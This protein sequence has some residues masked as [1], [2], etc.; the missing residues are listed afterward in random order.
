[1]QATD[2]NHA[3]N[4]PDDASS[5]HSQLVPSPPAS[6][7]HALTSTD[8]GERGPRSPV[9]KH[10]RKA[11]DYKTS[12][13]TT[14]MHCG[15]TVLASCGSTTAMHSHLKRFHPEVYAESLNG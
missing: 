15:K 12:R 6:P 13:K 14:C 9:W 4:G 10:F 7:V 1:M 8:V 5:T 2:T 11:A 3:P